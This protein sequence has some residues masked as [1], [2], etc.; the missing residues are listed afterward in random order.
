MTPLIKSI[1]REA[2]RLLFLGLGCYYLTTGGI[3]ALGLL[4]ARTQPGVVV[5]PA[6]SSFG[7]QT[8]WFVVWGGGLVFLPQPAD[9]NSVPNVGDHV[10]VLSW[11]APGILTTGHALGRVWKQAA[12]FAAV[13]AILL[14][15]S[16]ILKRRLKPLELSPGKI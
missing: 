1:L 12:G 5:A 6:N 14:A 16:Y 4:F 10:A 9:W 13:G 15:G 2:T 11:P 3:S 8:N 7:Q